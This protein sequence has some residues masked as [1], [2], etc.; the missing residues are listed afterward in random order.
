MSQPTERQKAV[1]RY[2]YD[3]ISDQGYPPTVRE[4]GLGVNLSSS[5]TVHGHLKHL[6]EKGFLEKDKTKPRAIGITAKGISTL[7]LAP[8]LTKMPIIAQITSDHADL[9]KEEVLNYCPIP[10]QYHAYADLFMFQIPHNNLKE[11]GILKGD[12]LI[13]Q[14]Q[15]ITAENDLII[16]VDENQ[17]IT[18]QAYTKEDFS[19]DLIILGKI[20]GFL[21]DFT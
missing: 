13:I 15:N 3:Y 6:S 10:N 12:S 19:R 4:I 9:S 11:F 7:G 17:Q 8:L 16:A 5:S 1:L 2:I 18:Y 20:I 21:R 14:K